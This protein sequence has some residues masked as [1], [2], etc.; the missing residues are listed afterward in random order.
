MSQHNRNFFEMGCDYINLAHETD[1]DTDFDSDWVKLT[2]YGRA[3][4]IIKKLGSEDVDTLGFQFLQALTAAGGSAKALNVSRY[5]TKQ[6]TMTSQG[7]W[8][9]GVLATPDDIVGIGS[10]APS[11]GSLI[12]AVDVNTDACMVAIE[13][14]ASD[15]DADNGFDWIAVRVEGDEVNNAAKVSIDVILYAGSYPQPVPLSAIA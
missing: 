14:L 8:T 10:A 11:G 3:L 13:I 2:H 4:V 15:L 12:T 7:T 9:R 5:W 1:A 6:G